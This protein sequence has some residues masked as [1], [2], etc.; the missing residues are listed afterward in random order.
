MHWI[1]WIF[2]GFFAA[3]IIGAYLVDRLSSR[4]YNLTHKKTMNQVAAQANS[5]REVDRYNNQLF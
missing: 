2:W 3:I 5:D 4:N 1:M